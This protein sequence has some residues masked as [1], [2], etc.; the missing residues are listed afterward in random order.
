MIAGN[1]MID[2]PSLILTNHHLPLKVALMS[3]L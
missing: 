3:A 2:R 1:V